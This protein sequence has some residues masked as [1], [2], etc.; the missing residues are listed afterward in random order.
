MADNKTVLLQAIENFGKPE[1]REQYFDLYDDSAVLRGYAGVE[2]GLKS[3]KQFYAQFWAT[4][5]NAQL[6]VEDLIE[7]DDK[8]VCRFVV[9]ATH[10]GNFMGVP[11]TGKPVALPGITILRFANG[12]CVERWSQADFLSAMVQI[13][14]IPMPS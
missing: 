5:P 7:A 2:P 14:A 1:T 12:K 9:H 3:I 13:G 4:F 11:A 8:V 10:G 6:T